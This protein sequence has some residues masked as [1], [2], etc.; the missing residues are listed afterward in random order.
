MQHPVLCVRLQTD[1]PLTYRETPMRPQDIDWSS[2]LFK[3][4]TEGGVWALPRS[5]LI[6]KKSGNTLYLVERLPAPAEH[7]ARRWLE[8]QQADF[9][10]VKQHMEAAGIEVV[11]GMATN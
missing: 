8:Y 9:D 1:V 6:F 7:P 5:G 10:A 11:D 3:R 2:N 4:L